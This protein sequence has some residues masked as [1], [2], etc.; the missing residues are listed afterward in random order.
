MIW[1]FL[2]TLI[3]GELVFGGKLAT[4]TDINAVANF[5]LGGVVHDGGGGERWSNAGQLIHPLSN[6]HTGR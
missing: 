6:T 4:L 5:G 3:T 2:T 1:Y